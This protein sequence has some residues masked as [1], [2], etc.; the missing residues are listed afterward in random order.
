MNNHDPPTNSNPE[1]SVR[2]STL[3]SIDIKQ[4][5]S[6]ITV[7]SPT[8]S[9]HDI[10]LPP[11]PAPTFKLLFSFLTPRRKLVLL[12]PATVSS[13]VAGGIAPFM[14]YVIGQSFNTFAAFP[15][16]PNPSQAEKDALLHGV[17]FAA[18]QLVALGLG[19]L[20]MSSVTSSLWI[21]TGEWNVIELRRKVY[22]A[23][24]HQQIEWFDRQMGS[25]NPTNVLDMGG[26]GAPI[27]AGGLMAKFARETDDVR[28]ASSLAAGQ[29][30]QYLT[31]TLTALVLAFVWSPLLTLVILSAVPFLILIQG[32][33]QAFASPRIAQERTLIARGASLVSRVVSNIGAVKAANAAA[34]EHT[35]LTRVAV[36]VQSLGAIWGVTAGTSQFVTMA[37]FVQGFWYGAHLVLQ[38]RNQPGDV[39]SVFWAC[40]IATSNLQMMVPC[41][42]VLA[43]GKTAAA[44]LAAVI[45][46]SQ[47]VPAAII[48]KHRKARPL[49]R[50][51]PL[52]FA[53]DFTLANLT[54]SYPTRPTVPVLRDVD[55]FLPSRETTFIVGPSGCGKSTIGSILL[56]YYSPALGKGEVL[57]DEQDLRYL[58]ATWV[59]RHVAG[60][61]Q[62]SAGGGAQV[63]RGSIHWNVALG[64]VGSGRCVEDVTRAE[65]EEACRLAMLEGWVS[66]LEVGYETVLAGSGENSDV[67][68]GVVLSGGM[69]QRLALARARIRDPDVLI[70][71]ESTSALDPPT[72]HLTTAAIRAW[73]SR[74]K[75]TTIIIT[76][77]LTSI[78]ADD[79]VYVMREGRVAEQG[80]RADLG[81]ADGEWHGM[82]RQGGCS[83]NDT[84]SDTHPP[85]YE[86][87]AGI[88]ASQD[89]EARDTQHAK[90]KHYSL[91]PTLNGVR[92]VTMVIGGW[93]FD[94]VAELT[95]TANGSVQSEVPPL[96]TTSPAL[97]NHA[98]KFEGG[99]SGRRRR[100]SSMSIVVPS[101]T[102][103]PSVYDGRRSSLQLTHTTPSFTSPFASAIPPQLMVEDDEEFESEKIN[104]K[105]S[106][107]QAAG[108][109]EK[110][111][112]RAP[113]AVHVASVSQTSQLNS[114]PSA[115]EPL[116]TPGLIATL[117]LIYP[118]I[119][120]KHLLFLGL[121][122]SLLS[123]A[124]TPIFSFLLSR[125][126]FEVSANPGA[127]AI[128]S[129]GALVLGIAAA[130]GLVM[131]L[132][133]FFME[134]SAIRWVTRMR[135]T[136]YSRVLSQDKAWFDSPAHSPAALAQ[137]LV[138][139]ADDARMLVAVVMG[140]FV[141]VVAMMGVGL[142]WAM[143]WGWQLTL[144]GIAIGPVFIGV[145]ALQAGLVAKYE[146][147]N[148]RARE[149]VARVYYETI[150]NVRS[151]R[152]M[153][154][155][156]VLQSQFDKAIS[157]C[158]ATGV[159]GAFVEGCS[160][161]VASALIYFAE[162]LLFYVGAVLVANGTYTYLRMVQALNLVVFTVTIGSQLMSFTQRI[163]KSVQAT[164]D[165]FRFVTLP[166]DGTNE[167]QGI[168]RPP[169]AGDLVLQNVTFAYPA[170]PDTIVL[171]NLS[172]KIAEGECVAL[173]GASGC[174]KSTVAA[175]LQ[176]LYEPTS[177][178]I[179]VG[180][181]EL[182]CTDVHHLRNHVAVVNQTPNLFDGTIRENIAYGHLGELTD[183]DVGYGTL[184]GENAALISGGQAQRLQIARALVRPSK[185]LILDECTSAL[186]GANQ[187][188]VIETI[189]GAKVG[190][191]TVMV[192]HKVEVMRMCDRVVVIEDGRVAE[193]GPV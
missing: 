66:G 135:D 63:F 119:P 118:T 186:D 136:A 75:K 115:T 150:L 53:G 33:S 11:P 140:Q 50:I 22:H 10:P 34:Y 47:Q 176:R 72:R 6:D 81:K 187:A 4:H 126:M 58:D 8:S 149:E 142:V 183:D 23:V 95:K 87:V 91:A 102:V 100:P 157:V 156:P 181:H 20:V 193:E 170:N 17:G 88:L 67:E 192:T 9:V 92:P 112:R 190:R 15:L 39:M 54:F 78:N 43:K 152:A 101:P 71:D 49:R 141:V 184:V 93:M 5:D 79:F 154:L 162:A 55:M 179:S 131:G 159:R 114:T 143:V 108:R 60:V 175:L 35:L 86:E 174:G 16:T 189:R 56:G 147:R 84:E 134:T 90:D 14:T 145:M 3:S 57:L 129:Y 46:S 85:V 153:S 121:I 61:T 94:V 172:M 41:L 1:L 36:A 83:D 32:F 123:G 74:A 139:D 191:T 62:G 137:V 26:E 89:E 99:A 185:I 80:F 169:I 144:V 111:A 65:V 158:L 117:R 73:R 177:G 106:A 18:L 25:D 64:A 98:T 38:G 24:V 178:M 167:A 122:T 180:A 51:R 31:T 160:Y 13:V 12:T 161:G 148:K 96:P 48:A 124:M 103:P 105:R 128:N 28:A 110:R 97:L 171:K 116:P 109:R 27:G 40:L 188:A 76:H 59:R 42:V 19:A 70:L 138:K 107:E 113:N 132:K 29:L 120:A 164:V 165:L 182:R 151:I 173:V 7:S 146:V 68:G 130:D 77:D 37:M 168:L 2:T 21:W 82:L 44:E 155:E 104:L 69:R 125:L 133:Y 166:I 45:S 163:A 52:G 30:I 127:A